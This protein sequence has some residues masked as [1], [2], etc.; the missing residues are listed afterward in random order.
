MALP[1]PMG[2]VAPALRKYGPILYQGQE[3]AAGPRGHGRLRADSSPLLRRLEAQTD[4][5][6]H[7]PDP[8]LTLALAHPSIYPICD[9]SEC[10]K[11]LVLQNGS[12][13]IPVIWGSSAM[14]KRNFSEGPVMMV[15][16]SEVL[17][18]S[19]DSLP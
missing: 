19:D 18:Q 12:H 1:T 15:C 2:N 6:S 7:H 11:G 17:N 9:T 8:P 5:L 16:G 10:A 14:S 4:H 3:R 13:R